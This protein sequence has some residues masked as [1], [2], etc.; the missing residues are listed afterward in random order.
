MSLI[1]LYKGDANVSNSFFGSSTRP[2][3]EFILLHCMDL[4]CAGWLNF[5]ILQAVLV[6][7]DSVLS[8]HEKFLTNLN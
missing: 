5:Y 8:I 1:S 3:T 4:V 7:I 6:Q 2:G